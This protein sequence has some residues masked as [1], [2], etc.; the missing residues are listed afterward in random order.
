[1][2]E[3]LKLRKEE[4]KQLGETIMRENSFE[5]LDDLLGYLRY[6]EELFSQVVDFKWL[7]TYFSL[8]VYIEIND[9]PLMFIPN[10]NAYNN[11]ESV[12][13]QPLVVYHKLVNGEPKRFS[14]MVF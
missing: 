1:M 7:V 14:K 8:G 11:K 4:A 2:N 10:G 6:Y 3:V 13:D 9:R 5:Y 12:L